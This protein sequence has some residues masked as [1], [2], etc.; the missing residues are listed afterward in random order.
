VNQKS[1]LGFGAAEIPIFESRSV[2][3][4]IEKQ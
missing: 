1:D 4:I 2:Y 3:L